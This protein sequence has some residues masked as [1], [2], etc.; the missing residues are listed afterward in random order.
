MMEYHRAAMAKGNGEKTDDEA[1][2]AKPKAPR[3]RS[4]RKKK[5]DGAPATVAEA[6]VGHRRWVMPI[7]AWK[8]RLLT[9]IVPA[10][11]LPFNRDQVI[12]S[13]EDNTAD[14]TKLR[15]DFGWDPKPFEPT[16]REYAKQI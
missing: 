13:Q 15:K 16:L 1:Q 12:M 6:V 8:A 3:A 11:L 14:I 7:P 10:A 9:R 2:T 4:Q 5:T